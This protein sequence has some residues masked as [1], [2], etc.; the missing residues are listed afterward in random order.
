MCT[1]QESS[2]PNSELRRWTSRFRLSLG[3]FFQTGTAGRSLFP[4]AHL[5]VGRCSRD[6]A[7]TLKDEGS[8]RR[9]SQE[10]HTRLRTCEGA[11][12]ES[13]GSTTLSEM[14]QRGRSGLQVTPRWEGPAIWQAWSSPR[15]LGALAGFETFGSG[16]LKGPS[17]A[18]LKEPQAWRWR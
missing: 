7:S 14:V 1:L 5:D 17:A 16:S 18:R 13:S 10:D 2:S 12:C 11:R 6:V 9:P 15:L 4:I 3:A 8:P